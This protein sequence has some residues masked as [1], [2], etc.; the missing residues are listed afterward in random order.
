MA[1]VLSQSG[2]AMTLDEAAAA[3]ANPPAARDG[4]ARAVEKAPPLAA[5]PENFVPLANLFAGSEYLSHWLL[6]RPGEIL[7]LVERGG[8]DRERGAVEMAESLR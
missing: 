6:A 7:W 3:T 2:G 5:S 8:L 4:L 1:H